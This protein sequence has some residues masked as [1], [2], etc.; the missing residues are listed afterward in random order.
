MQGG[1]VDGD[2]AQA[3]SL[4]WN[5]GTLGLGKPQYFISKWLFP[6]MPNICSSERWLLYYPD[7]ETNL[8]EHQ[9]E[10]MFISQDCHTHIHENTI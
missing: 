9:W 6:N 2:T 7:Q 4:H 10:E 1:P 8:P 5:Y 3:V